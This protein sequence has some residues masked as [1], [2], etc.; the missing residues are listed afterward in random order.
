MLNQ[1][2]HILEQ[3]LELGVLLLFFNDPWTKHDL[4]HGLNYDPMIYPTQDDG[5]NGRTSN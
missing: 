2:T 3:H 4:A 5:P 1:T